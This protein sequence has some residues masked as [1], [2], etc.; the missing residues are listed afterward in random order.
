[1]QAI[2]S[3]LPIDEVNELVMVIIHTS[4]LH[5]EHVLKA[6]PKQQKGLYIQPERVGGGPSACLFLL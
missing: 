6:F 4:I 2:K 3:L 5:N 1:M